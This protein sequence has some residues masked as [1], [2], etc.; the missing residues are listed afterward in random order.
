MHF[1]DF[2]KKILWILPFL[3]FLSGYI[4]LQFF[5]Q[6]ETVICPN[7]I[8]KEI[9]P[10]NQIASSFKINLQIIAEKEVADLKP[11]TI[12]KQNP[13]TGTSI[14]PH[15]SIFIVITK[16]PEIMQ[17]PCLIGKNYETIEQL[18]QAKKIKNRSYFL[19]HS[20]PKGTCFAQIPNPGE[21]LESKKIY[22]YISAGKTD[23]YLLPDF[24]DNTLDQVIPFLEQN[25]MSY[26]IFHKDQKQ[27]HKKNS[28][29]LNQKPLPGSLMIPN[30]KIH[31]QLQVD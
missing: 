19:P 11:G 23:P 2:F 5:I 20:Q 15:Q 8:G 4:F 1:S 12:I 16:T 28:V 14:K 27:S 10:A 29:I 24:T 22:T 18:T 6:Q 3:A 13:A 26:T 21:N 7:F 9:L 25:Y 31:V 17:A 30:E